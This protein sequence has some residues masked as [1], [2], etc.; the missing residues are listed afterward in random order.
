[1]KVKADLLA[2]PFDTSRPARIAKK[3]VPK[4]KVGA[5]NTFCSLLHYCFF[6]C[7][8][9]LNFSLDIGNSVSYL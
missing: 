5:L 2:G 6:V 7:F 8:C 1:M 4:V 9:Y 3:E